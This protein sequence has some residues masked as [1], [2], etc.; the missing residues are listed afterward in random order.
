MTAKKKVTQY[1]FDSD[2]F[3]EKLKKARDDMHL[4]NSELAE[5]TGVSAATIGHYIKGERTPRGF[6]DICP[7]AKA[8]NVSLDYLAGLCEYNYLA[9]GENNGTPY[10]QNYYDVIKLINILSE[11]FDEHELTEMRKGTIRFEISDEKLANFLDQQKQLYDMVGG[12]LSVRAFD[13]ALDDL[14]EKM[15][16]TPLEKSFFRII[17][18]RSPS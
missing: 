16:K 8:L 12:S 4:R 17:S 3:K 7:I 6:G 1:A 10:P 13:I 5:R 11:S 9:D 18:E 15:K 2:A 14:N